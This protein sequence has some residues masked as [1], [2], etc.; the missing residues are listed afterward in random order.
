MMSIEYRVLSLH[1]ILNFRN[2][3]VLQQKRILNCDPSGTN[4]GRSWSE[5]R[6]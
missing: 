6:R 4:T 1:P 2:T 3:C 5:F